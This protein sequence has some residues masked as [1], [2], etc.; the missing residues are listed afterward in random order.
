MYEEKKQLKA[1]NCVPPSPE[2]HTKNRE[3][4]QAN[5]PLLTNLEIPVFIRI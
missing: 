4:A 3:P 2:I 1:A 5:H